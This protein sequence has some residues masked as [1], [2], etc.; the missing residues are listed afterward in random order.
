[1]KEIAPSILSADF[2]KLGSEIQEFES[3]GVNW[4]H[5]DIMDGHFVPNL[6]FGPGIVEAIRE[7]SKSILDCHLMVS[8]PERMV[9]WFLKAGADYVTIHFEAT[10]NPQTLLKSIRNAG[11]KAGLSL[12]PGTSIESIEPFLPEVD[13]VLVMSVEPGFGG[14][15]FMTNSLE[16]VKRLKDL[17]ESNQYSYLIEIDGGSGN[18]T[19]AQASEAG[20]DVFVAGSALFGA[21]DRKSAYLEMKGLIS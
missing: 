20:V 12:K 11:K 6:T 4:L 16:K 3:M 7:S 15:K 18:S 10:P 17:R 8:D 2:L 13:L 14:Q 19:A 9:P 1:M 5:L 21:K